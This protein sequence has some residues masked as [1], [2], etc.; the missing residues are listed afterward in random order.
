M[1]RRLALTIVG[2]VV[3]TLLLAGAGTLALAVA[4]ARS[5]TEADLRGQ[6]GRIAANIDDYLD[7]GEPIDT[8]EGQRLLRAR[9][10]L[11]SRLRDLL[12]VDEVVVLTSDVRGNLD[13]GELPSTIDLDDIEPERL[14]T[15]EIVSGTKGRLAYAA[16][17]APGPAGRMFVVVVTRR[18]EAGLGSAARLFV[19]A[20]AAT[21]LLG[22]AAAFLLGRRLSEPIRDASAATQ[23]IAAGRLSTRVAE[24]PSGRHDEV[25]ELQRSINHMASNLER[26]RGLEQQFLLSVSH[27]LRTPLTSIRGYAEALDDGKAD[28]KKA[29]AVIRAESKQLERLVADLLDLA[30]LQARSFTFSMQPVDVAAAVHTATTGAAGSWPEITFHPFTTGPLIVSADP[31][32]LAQALA[33]LVENAGRFA[34]STVAV[35]ARQENGVAVITVEDD[36][37]GIAAEDLPHVFERLYVARHAPRRTESSS[38]LGL[39]IVNELVT[40][41]GGTV[42]AGA[43]PQAGARLEIRLP[44]KSP[45]GRQPH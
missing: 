26:S 35:T 44:L 9:L 36:G 25:A 17:P 45:D 5:T 30:K 21:I 38:G 24:P 22:L 12:P 43:A 41:M 27:D 13:V 15:Y 7:V 40:A 32:R 8:A 34:R 29:A 18:V 10:R 28:P 20:A 11:L 39:A 4:S 3:T 19:W 23:Q 14:A 42:S 31:D 37:P 1:T 2:V 33:N 16:A 6:A